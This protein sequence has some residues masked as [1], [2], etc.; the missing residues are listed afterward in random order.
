MDVPKTVIDRLEELGVSLKD[1]KLTAVADLDIQGDF[2]TVWVLV[3][4]EKIMALPEKGRGMEVI[5]ELKDVESTRVYCTV[6]SAFFQARVG[7]VYIDIARFTN[8]LRYKFERLSSQIENLRAGKL[9]DNKVLQEPHP[10]LCKTCGMPLREEGAACPRCA[11]EGGMI[12]RLLSLI[13]PYMHWMVAIFFITAIA[14]GF[15]LVPPQLVRILVD[16]VLTTKRHTEWLI[17]LVLA[18]IGTE[19]FRAQFNTLIGT[20]STSV[21]TLIT[22]SLRTR[23]FR[24]LQELSI[25]YYDK[26]SAG[27]IMTRFSSDVEQ[28]HGFVSQIGQGFLINILLFIGIG[29]MLFTINARLA[30]YV[31]VPIPFVVSGTW[32]FWHKIYPRYYKLWDS[33]AKM[34][35]FL[36][37]I[38]SGIRLVRAFAQEEKEIERFEKRAMNLRDANRAVNLSV[39]AFN[40]L[41]A[42][43]FSLGGLI[44][45]YAGGKSVLAEKLTLG[46]LMAFLSYITMFYTPLSSLTLLSNWFSGFITA[47]HRIFEILDTEPTLKPP[48]RPVDIKKIEGDIEFRNVTFGY[49]PYH[50][51]LKNISFKINKGE[52]IGIVGKSGSGKTTIVNLICRFYDPQQGVVLLDGYD[53]RTIPLE[54]IHRNIGI[55]LQEPFLF[56]GT[57]A[58]NISYGNPKAT[59]KEIIAA[60]KAANIHESI[61]QMPSGYDF[62]LGEGGAG[63]SGGERQR[64]GIARVLLCD[65]PVLI[66]DEATSSVDTESEIKIQEALAVLCKGRTTIAIA[67]RLSTLKDADRLYVIDR[68]RIVE[69]GSHEELMKSRGIYYK[70][71]EAQTKLSTIDE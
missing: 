46:E 63:L 51:V 26:N 1:I 8:I 31:L 15:N 50:P 33:Q 2:T 43:F 58:E 21:G 45:W 64:V 41:M 20:L 5:V 65:P 37:S 19:V 7:G 48:A 42:F 62:Y 71:V 39:A 18:L 32:F 36:H 44:V 23:M 30:I 28:L 49:D 47:T 53:A 57:I 17:W 67:H 6:G 38:I 9:V 14:V 60:A 52:M 12:K 16:D 55:V 24:K 27:M 70:L 56:R 29:I 61:M 69:Y 4:S 13:M 59:Y 11:K 68:G 22:Y 25:D 40:P 66:L 10:L 35:S 3:S 54:V 34:S